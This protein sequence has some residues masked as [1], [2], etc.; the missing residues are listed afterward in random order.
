MEWGKETGC[1]EEEEEEE[2]E[3]E[4][5]VGGFKAA[6]RCNSPFRPLVATR[7]MTPRATQF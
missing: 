4:A 2:E 7:L 6:G 1:M 3:E 5:L